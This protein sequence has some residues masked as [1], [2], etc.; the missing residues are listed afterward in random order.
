VIPAF[1]RND[2]VRVLQL[3]TSSTFENATGGSAGD[4]LTGGTVANILN[5]G[6]STDTMNG[7]FGRDTLSSN[8]DLSLDWLFAALI[9]SVLQDAGDIGTQI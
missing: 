7:F 1:A 5:G 9:D 3:N 6:G 2:S 4:S 8:L